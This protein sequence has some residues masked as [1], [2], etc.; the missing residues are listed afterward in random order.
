MISPKI[1][2]KMV[3]RICRG[4]S[5][6]IHKIYFGYRRIYKSDSKNMI[7][8]Q[9]WGWFTAAA[10]IW[11]L[12]LRENVHPTCDVIEMECNI[13]PNPEYVGI[14]AIFFH[15]ILTNFKYQ[16]RSTW[17]TTREIIFFRVYSKFNLPCHTHALNIFPIW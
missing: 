5:L 1:E 7:N 8:I 3:W 10:A 15:K 17:F 14:G 13:F 4:N 11:I 2:T 9:Y 16:N 6:C 12:C